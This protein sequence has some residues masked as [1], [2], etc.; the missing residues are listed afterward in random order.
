VIGAFV[1]VEADYRRAAAAGLACYEV[2]AELA[3]AQARGPASFKA[4]LFDYLYGLDRETV[5]RRQ[6]IGSP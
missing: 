2:A 4:A 5:E 1:A 3:A 6:R